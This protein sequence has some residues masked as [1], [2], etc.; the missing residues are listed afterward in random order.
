MSDLGLH[1]NMPPAEYYADPH[2]VGP[3]LTQSV[4]KVLL[5]SCPAHA[6]RVHPRGG[7]A[8]HKETDAQRRG[9]LVDAI[10][11][12][13][14]EETYEIGPKG[15]VD[16]QL[17]A[18]VLDGTV[19]AKYAV[20]PAKWPNFSFK[21]ARE[22]QAEREAEGYKVIKPAGLAL[23]EHEAEIRRR[24]KQRVEPIELARARAIAAAAQRFFTD[25]D[26]QVSALWLQ[27]DVPCRARLDYL[28]VQGG[29]A[30]IR[31]LKTAWSASAGA[32]RRSFSAYGYDVQGAAYTAAVEHLV[33]SVRE[34]TVEFVYVETFDPYLTRIVPL[35]SSKAELGR[36]KWQWAVSKWGQCLRAQ[37]FAGYEPFAPEASPW[38]FEAVEAIDEDDEQEE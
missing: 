37:R 26:L 10:V 25:G 32:I 8:P 13:T 34:I 36:R 17:V 20:L 11:C 29:R 19:A 31:D 33:P 12:G 5:D 14:F 22:W 18:A 35:S 15:E 1:I 3:S 38:E 30:L 4:A 2:P 7:N 21:A 23:A 27:E 28:R 16:E 6:W 9:N 24:G